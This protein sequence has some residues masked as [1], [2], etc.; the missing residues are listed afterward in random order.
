MKVVALIMAGGESSRFGGLL[1]KPMAKLMGEY[2]I[3]RVVKAAKAAESISEIYV[4][5]TDR[6]P[7]TIREV[8]KISV[9]LVKTEGISYHADLQRAILRANLKCPVLTLSCDLPLLTG[10]FLDE[11]VSNYK[12]SGKPA[13]IVLAPLDAC[14]KYGI[15]PSS[16][17]EHEG[18]L[19]VVSGINI[20]DGRRILEG[21]QEQ[22]VMISERLEAVFNV[23]T[24]RELELARKILEKRS[25][26]AN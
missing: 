20:V 8:S 18:K 5:A 6:T 10:K 3:R 15:E 17:Y 2:I 16:I 7:K 23:N 24:H 4:A 9:K 25:E 11:V 21:E 14:Y 12:K 19:F 1:E 13:L 26:T 22:E